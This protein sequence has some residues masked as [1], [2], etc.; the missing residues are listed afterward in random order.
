MGERT[1]ILLVE[2]D[3]ADQALFKRFIEHEFLPYDY[4]IVESVSEARKTLA[5]TSFDIVLIDYLLGDGTAFDLFG[6]VRDIPLIVITRDGDEEIAIGAMRAGALDYMV[7]DPEGNYLKTLPVTVENVIRRKQAEE[8]LR[9]YQERLEEL[10]EE[11]TV[12]LTEANERFVAEI[13]ERVR[14]EEERVRVEDALR[15][16]EEYA[17]TVIDSSLDMIVTVGMERQIVGFNK[18]AQEGFGYTREEIVGKPVSVLYADQQS[19]SAIQD[20][21]SNDGHCIQEIFNK[22][23]DGTV[24]P[25]FLSASVMRNGRGEMVGVMSISRDITERKRMEKQ[26]GQQERLAAVGQLAGGIAHDFNNIMATII[27]S[28]QMTMGKRNLSPDVAE[29]LET[30]LGESRRAAKLVQQILDFGRRSMIDIQPVNLGSFVEKVIGVLKQTISEN[31][32]IILDVQDA[33]PKKYMARSILLA[34]S[35]RW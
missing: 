26:L 9:Q 12:E 3:K 18:A 31:V 35:R 28:T 29:A 8:K 27:L 23:K 7:K 17:R 33:E 24:F 15:E 2:N 5:D 13:A 11:R 22:R 21:I 14:S 19:V 20:A 30:I 10:V 16:S 34:S 25:T 4:V 6:V 32:R 1:S